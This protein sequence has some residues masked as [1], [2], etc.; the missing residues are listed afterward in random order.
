MFCVTATSLDDEMS[1]SYIAKRSEGKRNIYH[2]VEHFD[3][4]HICVVETFVSCLLS[5][6]ND[7]VD[8]IARLTADLLYAKIGKCLCAVREIRA[9]SNFLLKISFYVFCIATTE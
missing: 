8:L 1:R 6:G 9:L 5:L 3:L 4:L 2:D 7:V